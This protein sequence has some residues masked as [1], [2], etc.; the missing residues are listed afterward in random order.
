MSNTNTKANDQDFFEVTGD[1]FKLI[2][3]SWQALLLNLKTFILIAIMPA[4]AFLIL[5][6]FILGAIFIDSTAAK[7]IF[8]LFS[9]L[10]FLAAFAVALVFIPAITY[11][12]IESARKKT[13]GFDEAVKKGKKFALKYLG[14]VILLALSAMIGLIFLIVPGLLAIFFFSMATY[15]LIDQNTGIVDAMK[16]SYEIVKNNWLLVLALFIVNIVVS[17]T[18]YVPIIGWLINLALSVAYFCLP[19]IIYNKISK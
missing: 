1:T 18:S 4:L 11:V 5:V 8:I 14:L 16:K 3:G 15:I 13:V 10:V 12:Q 9:C 6:P 2:K 17:F 7:T 19:A